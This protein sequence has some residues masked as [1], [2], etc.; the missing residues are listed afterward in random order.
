[1]NARLVSCPTIRVS[2]GSIR[3]AMRRP[4]TAKTLPRAPSC[5]KITPGH[6]YQRDRGDR[7][8]LG[9]QRSRAEARDREA[10]VPGGRGLVRRESSL[11]S[12]DD[13][14]ASELSV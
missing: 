9:P 1:M 14:H 6:L 4:L 8:G 3:K 12:G 2:I 11:R 10:G 7:G 5:Q 13:E